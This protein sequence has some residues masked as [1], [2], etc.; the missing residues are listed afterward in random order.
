MQIKKKDRNVDAAKLKKIVISGKLWV[1]CE[2]SEV[3]HGGARGLGSSLNIPRDLWW[4]G[5]HRMLLVQWT[6]EYYPQG[7]WR[8]AL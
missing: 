8:Q 6:G 3:G 7:E 1:Y 4:G 2:G 5:G